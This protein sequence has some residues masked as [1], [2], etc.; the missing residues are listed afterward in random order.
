[1]DTDAVEKM[2]KLSDTTIAEL[3]KI[4][5]FDF[6]IFNVRESTNGN[7]MVTVVSHIL[8]REEIF[9]QLPI[10]NEKFLNFMS[11]IQSS[12]NDI[13]YHNKTH[14]SDLA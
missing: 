8:A 9:D 10:Q 5:T 13:T 3:N 2:L 12:Y 7:E 4:M 14:G 6:N 1:M 11:K